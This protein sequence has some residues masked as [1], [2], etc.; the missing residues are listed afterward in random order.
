[1][2]PSQDTYPIFEDNQ[3]LTS[4]HLNGVFG[5]LDE[6]ERLTR[7]NLIGIG[8]VCGLEVRLD[9]TAGEILL[10][11]GGGITS[12]GYLI[13]EPEDVTLVSFMPYTLPAELPYPPFMDSTGQF[14]LW[15]LFPTVEQGATLI[16]DSPDFLEG[17]AVLLF[18]ELKRELSRNCSLNDC[19][20]R[21]SAVTVTLRRLLIDRTA[22]DKVIAKANQLPN[23]GEVDLA[24]ALLAELNLPDL[25]LPRFD[26][27][28]TAPVTAQQV[29]A[30]ILALFKS[31]QIVHQ[32]GAAL[33]AAYNAFKPLLKNNY[34]FDPFGGF[35]SRFGFLDAVPATTT[36]VRFLQYYYDFF[37]D[38]LGAYN[39]FRYHGLELLCGC[40][41]PEGLFPRHLM[42][43]LLLPNEVTDPGIYR[44]IFIPSP[45]V[46]GCEARTRGLLQLFDRLVEMIGAFTDQPP[47]PLLTIPSRGGVPVRLTPSKLGDIPLSEKAIP[48]YYLEDG[49]PPLY[50]LWSPKKTRMNR[51][52]QNL[53][54]RSDEYIPAPPP[55]VTNPMRYDLE[56]YNFLRIEGHIG[57]SYP[58]VLSFLLSLKTRLRL[59]IDIIALRSGAFDEN[60]PVDIRKEDCRFQDLDA[61]YD[62]LRA[63]LICFLCKEVLFFY[64][65]TF[66][67]QD[68]IAKPSPPRLPLLVKCAP[69]FLVQPRTFGRFFE[70]WLASVN[71]VIPDIDPKVI[72]GFL[73]AR[74][75]SLSGTSLQKLGDTILAYIVMFI[76]KLADQLQDDLQQFDFASFQKRYQDLVAVT[77]V[78]EQARDKAAAAAEGT[79]TILKLEEIDDRLED[80]LYRCRMEAFGALVAEYGRRIRQVKEAQFLSTFLKHHPGVQHKGGVPMGGTFILVYHTAP[81]QVTGGIGIVGGRDIG[82]NRLAKGVLG[83]EVLL[84]T[85]ERI[86]AKED[87]IVD[88]DLRFLIS[89]LTGKDPFSGDRPRP[90]GSAD[91]II[92]QAIQEIDDGTIIAD[93]YLPY[94]CCSDCPPIQFVLPKLPP[95]FTLKIGCTSANN[96]AEVIITPEGGLSPY[97]VKIDNQDYQPLDGALVVGVGGHTISLRDSE[98]VE[99]VPQTVSIP[100]PLTLTEPRF[101]CVG[102][103]NEYVASF[104]IA[105]GNSPYTASRGTVS[106]SSY[107]SDVLPG[108]TDIEIVITDSVGCMASAKFSHSCR[109]TVSFTME[110]GCSVENQA[111]VKITP[112]GGT[113]PYQVR[114]DDA[115]PT[116]LPDAITLAV[117]S[118]R[119]VLQ[120]SA[121]NVTQPQTAVIPADLGLKETGFTCEGTATYRSTIVITGG[122]QPYSVNGN[123]IGGNTFTTDPVQS[124]TATNVK[125]IDSRKCSATLE[126]QHTCEEPCDLPCGGESIRCAFRLWLQRPEGE[127]NYKAYTQDSVIKLIFNNR[128]IPLPDTTRLLQIAVNALNNS[129]DEALTKVIR[130]L[131]EV[132]NTA[133]VAA[134]GDAGKDRLVFS[135]ATPGA[136]R[137]PFD[138]LL[139]EHFVCDTF[140]LEFNCSYAKPDPA[141]ALTVR[142]TSDPTFSGMVTVNRRLDNKQIRVPAFA[143]AQRNLCTH[144]DY[145]DLC[146]RGRDPKTVAKF[147]RDGNDF[148]CVGGIDNP[149]DVT[150]IAWVW[151][152]TQ[153]QP[154]EPFYEGQRVK[155]QLRQPAGSIRLTAITKDGCF[156]RA[157]RQIA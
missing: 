36:Q 113:P 106:G 8:I 131:N 116:P 157:E 21:G 48:Y 66:E 29:L 137:F 156:G 27:P 63:E 37:D 146:R 2:K 70:D 72:V 150:V 25:R 54:F 78:I 43:G 138:V 34:P 96:Q 44:N 24:G 28:N 95:R 60:Q 118:H 154:S 3:V 127:A 82:L 41:P 46:S 9:S 69:N 16:K 10:T 55:F 119:V 136:A 6:Q 13:V 62:T 40:C 5:Y 38:L 144:T 117:G 74:D 99:A 140:T 32:V 56:P 149:N 4:S 109:V 80:I 111:Q 141:Y 59:P 100:A 45:A 68:T 12:E 123:L 26:V 115:A 57:K 143:C 58:G 155:A 142:Y 42:L 128:E 148:L 139:I 134:L 94:L 77:E 15:E 47:L 102:E 88:P 22:L 108:D 51:A 124:G 93:F 50:Q 7:A 64:A 89:N 152:M 145:Q 81:H 18:M 79:G 133:M 53:S 14:E 71:D 91:R 122:T 19:D 98:S 151:D 130:K 1:M 97:S 90:L 129:F 110:I 120:D 49:V 31:E 112:A 85:I 20:D 52:N 107:S 67:L 76:Q 147:D 132:V 92:D 83:K 87:L 35:I 17:K 114:I 65:L 105:G 73:N 39:E 11:R 23:L 101:D 103:G 153:A 30:A 61:L 126:L 33:S 84:E 104:D 125:V 121:G 135:P 86:S 75:F